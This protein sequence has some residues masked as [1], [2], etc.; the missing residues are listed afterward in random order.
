MA[1]ALPETYVNA[2]KRVAITSLIN[3]AAS[4]LSKKRLILLLL[5]LLLIYNINFRTI[6]SGDTTPASLLPFNVLEYHSLTLDHFYSYYVSIGLTPYYIV[7]EK[8]V[9]VSMYPI[10]TPLLI[11]PF[12]LIPYELLKLTGYPINLVDPVFS[13]TVSWMEKLCASFIASLSAIFVYLSLRRIVDEK[14]VFI[15]TIA[16]AL[17]TATFSISSQGLWQQGL[18]ELLLSIMIYV[19][20]KN[21]STDD[22]INIPLIGALSGL[23]FFNRPSDGI[24]LLPAII[25]VLS[26]KNYKKIFLFL[27]SAIAASIPFFGYNYYYFR[28]IFGGYGSLL[29]IFAFNWG[30]ASNFLGLLISPNRGI[31]VYTPIALFS[32]AGLFCIKKIM[33]PRLR[34]FLYVSAVAMFLQVFVYSCFTIWWAGYSYGPRFLAGMLP[35]V[36]MFISLSLPGNI[37]FKAKDKRKVA[38]SAAFIS[39]LLISISIQAI[40]VFYYKADWDSF[41]VSIDA[42]PWRVWDFHDTQI[43]RSFSDGLCQMTFL[44]IFNPNSINIIGS[45]GDEQWGSTTTQWLPN[46]SYIFY[47]SAIDHNVNLTF[48]ALSFYEDRPMMIYLNGRPAYEQLINVSGSSVDVPLH[49]ENGYNN[50]TIYAIG[51]GQSPKDIPGSTSDDPRILSFAIQNIKIV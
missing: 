23:F 10:V 36:V 32:L 6:G 24:L 31:F 7:N 49:V 34:T 44:N 35:L 47:R 1:R 4:I 33:L 3:R 45:Y 27:I 18:S 2:S 12:Y 21:E 22:L 43:G 17:G 19:I 29:S 11:T 5:A 48:N 13:L 28:N 51:G 40:G 26:L 15:C 30:A 16:Y 38:I 25:Y 39:L 37:G 41:P 8:G 14:I 50:I 9:Y 20:I 42:A 46:T